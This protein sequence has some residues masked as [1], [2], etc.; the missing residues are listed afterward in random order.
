MWECSGIY[1][2]TKNREGSTG[3]PAP[4]CFIICEICIVVF[5]NKM[6]ENYVT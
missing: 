1:I 5:A 4:L 3:M 6:N 2:E